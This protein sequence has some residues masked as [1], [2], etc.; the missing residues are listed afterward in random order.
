MAERREFGHLYRRPGSSYWWVR[1]RVNG[2]TYR[3][4]TR[5]TSERKAA[6]LLMQRRIELGRGDFVAPDA[7]RTSFDDL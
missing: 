1:Y 6:E 5:S 4:S 3:E 7:N 2:R